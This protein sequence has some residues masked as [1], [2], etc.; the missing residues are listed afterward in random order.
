MEAA[1]REIPGVKQAALLGYSGKR[2]LVIESPQ[3]ESLDHL[4]RNPALAWA[5]IDRICTVSHIPV[6]VRHNSK[7]DYSELRRL[8]KSSINW[9]PSPD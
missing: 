3:K 2:M 7:I 1:A 6:D 9:S 5:S 8:V 4:I